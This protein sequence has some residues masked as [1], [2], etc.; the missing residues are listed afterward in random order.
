[1]SEAKLT[2]LGHALGCKDTCTP[3]QNSACG[4]LHQGETKVNGF[5]ARC[6]STG[7]LMAAPRRP[8]IELAAPATH[9]EREA[10]ELRRRADDDLVRFFQKIALRRGRKKRS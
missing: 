10:A 2:E 7:P 9:M 8:R 5:P 3:D 4:G 6:W 1:M